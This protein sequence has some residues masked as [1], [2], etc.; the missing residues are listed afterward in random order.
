MKK[1]KRILMVVA[2]ITAS[3]TACGNASS[4]TAATAAE[5]STET[6]K[7]TT[8][9]AAESEIASVD[10]ETIAANEVTSEH[11]EISNGTW[12]YHGVEDEKSI[13]MD[14]LKGFTAYTADAIPETEGYLQYLGVNP[15]GNHVFEVYDIL[16]GRFAVMTFLSNE[17]FYLDENKDDYYVKWEY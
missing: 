16:G 4:V 15:D 7:E 6:G 9:S 10:W 12:F 17:K 11:Y 8:V 1:M 2:M 14:G 5:T 3:L 13:D